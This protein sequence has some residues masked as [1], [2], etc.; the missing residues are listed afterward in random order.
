MNPSEQLLEQVQQEANQLSSRAGEQVTRAVRVANARLKADN[1]KFLD[2]AK[3]MTKEEM[4]DYCDDTD[5]LL[6][7]NDGEGFL[8]LDGGDGE[9]ALLAM[10]EEEETNQDLALEEKDKGNHMMKRAKELKNPNYYRSALIH[11]NNAADHAESAWKQT[12]TS[13]DPEILRQA[14]LDYE[15]LRKLY[16]TI[17]SNRAAVQLELKN[18]G[19]FVSYSL[20]S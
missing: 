11:Y 5:C 4:S 15:E 10:E 9:N 6:F 20:P 14:V 1:Q 8:D 2:N 18:F 13:T 12:P 16:S 3:K 7:S 17:L 19:G